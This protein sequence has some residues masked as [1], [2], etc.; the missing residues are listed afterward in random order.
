MKYNGS[1]PGPA[2]AQARPRA[3]STP[4]GARVYEPE[5]CRNYKA[6]AKACLAATRL[7]RLLNG[8]IRMAI[9]VYILKPKS[10]PKKRRFA[11]TKPDA[12]NFAK[13]IC[14]CCEGLVYTNDSRV[15]DLHINK[16]LTA[17]APKVMVSIEELTM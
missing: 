6:Y 2:T 9:D 7:D 14:D 4:N 11:D 10:W 12:D 15:V 1:I 5:K 3:Y 13:M 17:T 8:P 16:F